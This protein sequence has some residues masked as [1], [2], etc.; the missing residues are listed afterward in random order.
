[1]HIEHSRADDS[2]LAAASAA[3]AASST[4][5]NGANQCIAETAARPADGLLAVPWVQP[6][7]IGLELALGRTPQRYLALHIYFL[8]FVSFLCIFVYH[9][10]KKMQ[11]DKKTKKYLFHSIYM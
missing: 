3:M 5:R 1:M 9:A 11:K 7:T 4:T 8:A 10:Y 2:G 6:M